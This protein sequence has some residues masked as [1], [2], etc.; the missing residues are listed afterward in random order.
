MAARL[1][2]ECYQ[3]GGI[4][5]PSAAVFGRIMMLCGLVD[6]AEYAT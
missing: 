3:V 4:G 5:L 6:Q 2:S 1:L